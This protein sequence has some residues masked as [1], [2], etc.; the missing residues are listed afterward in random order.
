MPKRYQLPSLHLS[1]NIHLRINPFLTSVVLMPFYAAPV[2][3][4]Y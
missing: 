1:S 4:E 3:L 2:T